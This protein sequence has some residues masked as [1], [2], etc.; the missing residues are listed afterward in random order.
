MKSIAQL[1]TIVALAATVPAFAQKPA[2][3]AGKAQPAATK[4]SVFEGAG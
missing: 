1:V 3:P 4:I 2:A